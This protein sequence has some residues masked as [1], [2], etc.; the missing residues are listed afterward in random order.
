MDCPPAVEGSNTIEVCLDD[1]LCAQWCTSIQGPVPGECAP[2]WDCFVL[3]ED[4][5][6]NEGACGMP[7]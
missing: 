4:A 2:G 5:D 6:Q 1:G 7:E 3:P